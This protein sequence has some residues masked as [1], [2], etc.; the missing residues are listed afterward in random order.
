MPQL[1]ILTWNS[2]GEDDHKAEWLNG[3]L[4][5]LSTQYSWHPDVVF[6][7]EANIALG[8]AIY[9]LLKKSSLFT[10][11]AAQPEGG[12]N[13][14][15]YLAA[16]APSANVTA[17]F[18]AVTLSGDPGV[19]NWLAPFPTRTRQTLATEIAGFRNLA[20]LKVAVGDDSVCLITWH[21]P[22]GNSELGTAPAK[23]K[24][25]AN[26]DAYLAFG[27][28]SFYEKTLKE[29]PVCC[30]AGDLNIKQ[31]AIGTKV[32]LADG[33]SYEVLSDWEGFGNRLDFTLGY[34]SGNA[35]SGTVAGGFHFDYLNSPQD[36][37]LVGATLN[38]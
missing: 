23:L 14:R 11:V 21:A 30:L 4:T 8:G 12:S 19:A 13:G 34:F 31:D 9:E 24:G 10:S 33:T 27:A 32:T 38:W 1:N 36:H 25:G 29:N 22:R 20:S 16:I 6:I 28:S 26:A 5:T 18:Q 37:S 17:A 15:A 2:G 3:V 7:Q 35:A